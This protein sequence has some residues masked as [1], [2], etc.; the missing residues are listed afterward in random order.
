[1]VSRW[2]LLLVLHNVRYFTSVAMSLKEQKKLLS[3]II[4][5]IFRLD[6]NEYKN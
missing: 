2:I 3:E 1:M 4:N 5:A 6:S